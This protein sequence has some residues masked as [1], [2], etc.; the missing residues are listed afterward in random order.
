[1]RLIGIS[2][3]RWDGQRA[4]AALDAGLPALLVR[5]AVLPEDLPDDPRLILH[6]RMVGAEA[7]AEAAGW[8]LHLPATGDVRAVRARFSG[9]LGISTHSDAEAR[10]ALSAGADYVL[11]SPIFP[12]TSKPDDRRPCLGLTALA[13][14]G[15]RYALGG[16]TPARAQAC[17]TAGAAGVAVLGGIFGA[18]DIRAAVQAYRAVLD[19]T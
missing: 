15:P 9:R 4:R 13:G 8:G 6:A 12:P 5:E 17:I 10:A 3:G 7:R 18:P 1:M 14:P 2:D 16:I 19:P 11:I